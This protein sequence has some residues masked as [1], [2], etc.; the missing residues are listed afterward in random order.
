MKMK[1]YIILSLASLTMLAST[2]CMDDYLDG[3]SPAEEGAITPNEAYA[4][5][6]AANAVM[7]GML[8]FQ[9]SQ[10]TENGQLSGPTTD[11]GGL[12]SMFFAR[13]VKGSDIQ[14][15]GSWYGA[16]YE[17]DNREPTYRRTGFTWKFPY[18][19]IAKTNQFINGV[20]SSDRLSD[21]EKSNL[22]AQGKALRAFYYFQLA[23]EFN[24]AYKFD[25][26]AVAPPVYTEINFDGKP[27]GTLQELY[28]QI[29]A[30]LEDA[31]ANAPTARFDSSWIN[32]QVAAAMLANVYLSMEEWAKAESMAKLAYGNDVAAALHTVDTFKPSGF[33]LYTDK[34]WLWSLPQTGDQTN[35][36]YMAPHV[37]MDYG[38]GYNN[39]F[40]NSDFVAKFTDN[41]LRKQAITKT[42][43][44]LPETDVRYWKTT[45]F[46][47]A[48]TASAPVIRTPEAIL[49]AAEAAYRQGKTSEAQSILNAFKATRYTGFVNESL[50]GD[51]LLEEILLERRKELYAENGVEWF[52]AKRLQRGITRTGNHRKILNI[53]PNDKLLI[54]K[55]P[56][57]EIDSNP[58]IDDSVNANR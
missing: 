20:S 45:K 49:V 38:V 58:N 32:K 24:H 13:S 15:S 40:L 16:D 53:A 56:Q 36:Y 57:V 5:Y 30:D 34:E 11:V 6:D 8:R 4:S 25:T 12:Y 3:P 17:H 21:D 33:D 48:F 27:M 7:A 42:S 52:D 22:I 31:V 39:G 28:A 47:F 10:W 2:A 54:L 29:V 23:L 41:D 26:Q 44:Q 35:Y 14:L 51:A 9:R 18:T 1:K 55:I 37:F 46:K 50:S 19:M 43:S